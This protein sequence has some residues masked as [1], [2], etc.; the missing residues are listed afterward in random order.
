MKKQIGPCLILVFVLAF[1]G[2]GAKVVE[3]DLR[4]Y[5]NVGIIEFDSNAKGNLNE[6]VMQRFLEKVS[7]LQRG[8]RI[9]EIGS[10]DEVL[11]SIKRGRI[12]PETIQAI[13]QKYKV[14]A[15][16][17]G[18]LNV[19]DIKPRISISSIIT[20]LSARAE[21]EAMMTVKLLE[22]HDGAMV[23]TR[24]VKQKRNVAHVSI[25]SGGSAYFDARD[26]EQAY[27]ELAEALIRDVTKGFKIKKK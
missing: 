14:D 16:I 17:I 18:D 13:G 5:G 2:C 19:S 3:V 20:S 15:I 4:E 11:Q 1:L 25:F 21:V 9:V 10:T 27:G 26:P 12:G 7:S 22:T 24:S 8:V 23:W 6:F